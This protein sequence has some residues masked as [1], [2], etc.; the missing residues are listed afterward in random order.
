MKLFTVLSHIKTQIVCNHP[1]AMGSF[2]FC[3]AYLGC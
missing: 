1:V 3:V 2:E